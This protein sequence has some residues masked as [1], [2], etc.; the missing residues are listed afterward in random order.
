MIDLPYED[1]I[2]ETSDIDEI[3]LE[4]SYDLTRSQILLSVKGCIPLLAVV[5]KMKGDLNDQ[6]MGNLNDNPVFD[7]QICVM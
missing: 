3:Y 2:I 5:E 7:S 1:E 4:E 6:L